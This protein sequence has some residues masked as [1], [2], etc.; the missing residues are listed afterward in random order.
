MTVKRR[1]SD[2]EL[3]KLIAALG[4]TPVGS[5]AEF[6]NTT[7]YDIAFELREYRT[8]RDDTNALRAERV[9]LQDENLGLREDLKRA[10]ARLAQSPVWAEE[11][12]TNKRINKA[13]EIIGERVSGL[14]ERIAAL[15]AGTMKNGAWAEAAFPTGGAATAE[16][17]A[18]AVLPV[19]QRGDRVRLEGARSIGSTPI[20]D[21][22]YEVLGQQADAFQVRFTPDGGAPS[23]IVGL[24]LFWIANNDPGLKEVRH[25]DQR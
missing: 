20:K 21:G 25:A 18:E 17:A 3:A 13:V 1:T 12:D 7:V 9:Q 6:S 19:P 4:P 5:R 15:E 8:L 14:D 2:D 23:D 10:E 22:W 16:A 24:G 11:R